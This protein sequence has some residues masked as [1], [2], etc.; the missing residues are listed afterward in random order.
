M[1]TTGAVLTTLTLALQAGQIAEAPDAL[2]SAHGIELSSD[3]RVFML[4]AALNGLGYS[5]ETERKK[6]PLRSPVFHPIRERAR[7]ALRKLE[8]EGKLGEIRKFFEANPASV[9]VYLTAVLAHDLSLAKAEAEPGPEAKKLAGIAPLL[10]KLG[11][12]PAISK[13]Y[14]ELALEQRKLA[15]ELLAR[16][17]QSF[18]AAAK[19]FN[20]PGLRAPLNLIV[21]PNPLDA[22]GSVRT[23]DVGKLRVLV[24]GPGLDSANRAILQAGLRG[25][26]APWVAKGMAGGAKLKKA[27]E[28][29]RTVRRIAARFRDAD[30]YATETLSR[31]LAFQILTGTKGKITAEAEEDFIETESKNDLRW[32]RAMLRALDGRGAEP[33]ETATAKIVARASP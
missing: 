19:S 18:D 13:L 32:A 15:L 21:V 1:L 11:S 23:L 10:Q 30:A 26:L 20:M 14:D 16:V 7:D 2:I 12:E 17:D 29:T 6:P 5:D 33:M 8:S 25:I 4:Y 27:W 22:H 24:V 9:D 28:S 3:G 31:V